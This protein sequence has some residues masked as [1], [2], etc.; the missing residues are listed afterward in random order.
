M[1]TGPY[2][3]GHRVPRNV[4][5]HDEPLMVATSPAAA[6]ELVL[7]L[8]EGFRRLRVQRGAQQLHAGDRR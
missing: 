6:A 7:L 3:Q 8:N 5:L 1:S 4:Y 2:R